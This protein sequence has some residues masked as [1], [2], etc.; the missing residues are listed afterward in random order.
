MA[1]V[2]L[3]PKAA[4]YEPPPPTQK[5]SLYL[6]CAR[7]KA[8]SVAP[9]WRK[10]RFRLGATSVRSLRLSS[11][12]V[13]EHGRA[14]KNSRHHHHHIFKLSIM[15]LKREG[16]HLGI[17]VQY[18][19]IFF[20]FQ[21]LCC[22]RPHL[23]SMHWQ[24]HLWLSFLVEKTTRSFPVRSF[25]R[26]TFTNVQKQPNHRKKRQKKQ[27]KRPGPQVRKKRWAAMAV[28]DDLSLAYLHQQLVWHV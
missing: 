1:Q 5:K 19:L 2:D 3:A 26:H 24:M 17:T 6:V 20:I 12:G 4:C 13:G 10:R 22:W 14:S 21:P 11:N 9:K 18:V 23:L 7:L 27:N 8:A 25:M 28:C 16:C 15:S